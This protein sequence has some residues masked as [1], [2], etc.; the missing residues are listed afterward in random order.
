MGN[1]RGS[2]VIAG[3]YRL[4]RALARGGMGAVWQAHHL[5]L[6][7]PVAIK[8]VD[9]SMT[10][11][12]DARTR[13][14]REARAAALLRS[15]HVVQ[16]LDHG[17][18]GGM[19]YIVMELLEG[20]NL[21]DR[22]Y[23]DRRLTIPDAA[24]IALQVLKAL[25]RAHDAGI[26]HRDLKPTNIFLAQIDDEEIVKVLDFGIAKTTLGAGTN[27]VTKTGM[28]LGSPSY[29]SPEQARDIKSVDHRAD[30]WSLGVILFRAL[31]GEMIFHAETNV[32]LMLK[33]CTE[34]VPKATSVAPD[35]PRDFD[36]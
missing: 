22:L 17:V 7:I 30:L 26:V 36:T 23:R 27:D 5:Q 35:L 11:A 8:F 34:E 13:F 31:T 33:L 20:E 9:A 32:D 2:V 29:M 19:H 6:D 28:I 14:E 3:K 15:P 12:A 25:R 1:P 16:I 21:G 24:N 18:D 10:A 4:V